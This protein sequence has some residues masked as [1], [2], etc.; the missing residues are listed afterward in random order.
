MTA[1]KKDCPDVAYV[2]PNL[3]N[4]ETVTAENQNWTTEIEAVNPDFFIIRNWPVS[5][6]RRRAA[7]EVN[8]AAMVCILG[9]TV[10][11]NLFGGVDPVGKLVRVKHV[12][13]RI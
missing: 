10:V 6:G 13:F 8:S 11:D 4:V 5:S 9:Q 3:S 12:P 1:I 7:A 2:A